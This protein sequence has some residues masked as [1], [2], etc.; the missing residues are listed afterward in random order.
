MTTASSA[1][2]AP[3]C[4]PCNTDAA[5]SSVQQARLA[6]SAGQD[7]ASL[8]LKPLIL[9]H[10][11]KLGDLIYA[12]PIA[13]WLHRTTGRKIHWVLPRRFVP[14]QRVES[15]LLRQTFSERLTLVDF[16]V[17]CQGCGGQ[18][19]H[20]NPADYGVAG[21]YLNLGFR[22]WPNEFV[23][24]F[25]AQEHGLGWDP[26]WVLDIGS[27]EGRPGDPSQ[28][29][30]PASEIEQMVATEQA[31][32]PAAP[33]ARLDLRKDVL[34]NVR[35]MAAARERHCFFSGLAAIL[36]FARVPFILYR[37]PWQPEL[38]LYF[39][40]RS[41]YELRELPSG[42]TPPDIAAERWITRWLVIR[43][44][45]KLRVRRNRQPILTRAA[46]LL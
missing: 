6:L 21:D 9:T 29:S 31:C 1:G 34:D 30:R 44:W 42:E 23:T 35:R 25:Q 27:H 36:Y 28:P 2:M 16:P 3:L 37:E 32:I 17:R 5:G 11:G 10:C 26:D 4:Q 15:L 38:D 18:P 14:F 40:D 12:W 20:F 13:A 46:K 8:H 22:W 43:E 33:E 19:Y 24:P 41:R 45:C 7:K 39:P